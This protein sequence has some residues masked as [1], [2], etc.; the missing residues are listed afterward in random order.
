MS[1]KSIFLLLLQWS[2]AYLLN[3][4]NYYFLG[5]REIGLGSDFQFSMSWLFISFRKEMASLK[6]I[7]P[8]NT[9]NTICSLA[10]TWSFLC[11]DW[12]SNGRTEHPLNSQSCIQRN[13]QLLAEQKAKKRSCPSWIPVMRQMN[14]IL[15]PRIILQYSWSVFRHSLFKHW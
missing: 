4:Y 3:Q 7:F 15:I 5:N 12:L 14:C 2:S 13:H 1:F 10:L 8:K 6:Y 11:Q 9:H